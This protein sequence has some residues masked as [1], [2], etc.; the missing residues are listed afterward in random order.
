VTNRVRESR[1][2][3]LFPETLDPA[4][5]AI[6]RFSDP[7]AADGAEPLPDWWPGDGRPL[8][9]VTFGSVAGSTPM[10]TG[11]Y[12]LALAALA[13]LPARIL[14][15]TG[16]ELDLPPA[17]PNIHVERWV[18]QRAVLPHAAVVAHHGGTGT[19]LGTLAAGIPQ[20]VTPLFADQPLN[21]RAIAGAGA[22]I[23]TDPAGLR[24][25]IERVLAG[26]GYADA[27]RRLAGEMRSHPPADAA[28]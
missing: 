16:H 21:A 7:A 10:G 15:T 4:P 1:F 3:S 2:V 5:L 26:P 13:D 18:P 17:A 12:P 11:M 24:E 6:E 23:A 28:F 8:V 25:A 20:V 9:Y 22:G 27:A 14:L 19:T